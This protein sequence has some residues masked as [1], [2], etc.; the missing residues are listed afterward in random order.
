MK[1]IKNKLKEAGLKLK[2]AGLASVIVLS[3]AGCVKEE[4]SETPYN[5]GIVTTESITRDSAGNPLGG[6]IIEM[7]D[8]DGV[9]G[10]D[11]VIKRELQGIGK[12]IDGKEALQWVPTEYFVKKGVDKIKDQIYENAKT[13]KELEKGLYYAGA[14]FSRQ[15]IPYSRFK[16]HQLKEI[17]KNKPARFFKKYNLPH[18][19]K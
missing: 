14:D 15:D 11:R 12:Y 4:I 5:P 16:E 3:L 2:E 10:Y 18:Y 19:K 9:P 8:H 7:I 1:N 17:R 13:D 6:Q